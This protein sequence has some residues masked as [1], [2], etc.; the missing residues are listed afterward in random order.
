MNLQI[1]LLPL[2]DGTILRLTGR[3][4]SLTAPELETALTPF[5]ERGLLPE[6]DMTGLT[7][8][9][10]AGLRVLMAAAKTLRRKGKDLT[11]RAVSPQVD[12][13]LRLAGFAHLF[14][15]ANGKGRAG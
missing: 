13:A 4:D 7:Y 14:S 9:S 12:Q 10:S 2:A 5:L 3:V 15:I 1:D 6:L 11:I 8:I